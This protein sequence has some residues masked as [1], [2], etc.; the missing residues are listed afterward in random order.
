MI[1]FMMHVPVNVRARMIELCKD[2]VSL[3]EESLKEQ[4]SL[5]TPHD[6]MYSVDC[7][8]EW[9]GQAIERDLVPDV[10]V[11]HA[12]EFATK[13]LDTLELFCKDDTL[14]TVV[15]EEFS[16]LMD[17]CHRLFL[18]CV[19][20]LV[21]VYN[22]QRVDESELKHSWEDVLCPR[23]SILFPDRD[24]PLSRAAGSY[25]LKHY[26]N[27]FDDFERRVVYDGS[28]ASVM[29]QVSCGDYDI[30]M[31]HYPF[32]LMGNQKN[33]AINM[34]IEGCILLPQVLTCLKDRKHLLPYVHSLLMQGSV[35]EYLQEQ[36][37]WS[38]HQDI[39]LAEN[40]AECAKQIGSWQGWQEYIQAVADFDTYPENKEPVS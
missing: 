27:Q 3:L 36:G 12:T 32:A 33:L 16:Q 8:E 21:M 23:Y 39:E 30:A 25:L 18:V 7:S 17:P 2:S 19:T 31:T 5:V 10:I 29:K 6:K 38:V 37:L 20:P 34:P 4:I 15:R 13:K 40:Y 9:L 14:Q 11:T 22:P 24:K 28:P 35:Q 1:R 26:P